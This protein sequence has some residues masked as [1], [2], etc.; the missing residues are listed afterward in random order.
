MFKTAISVPFQGSLSLQ[1]PRGGKLPMTLPSGITVL[2][3]NRAHTGL[4]DRHPSYQAVPSRPRP[5]RRVLAQLL[6]G[7]PV[8]NTCRNHRG[9]QTL[10]RNQCKTIGILK[11]HCVTL[12]L[13]GMIY[14]RHTGN[15]TLEVR[16]TCGSARGQVRVS[17]CRGHR[18]V[19]NYSS[20][21]YMSATRIPP[22][23]L[24][25]DRWRT[26]FGW[27]LSQDSCS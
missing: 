1:D 21:S 11:S 19:A 3:L 25:F 6:C 7:I 24:E 8:L 16:T 15:R 18:L 27:L 4:R 20:V 2:Y 26:L 5:G 12:F 14:P 22:N 9:R 13:H 17:H 23:R 10:H